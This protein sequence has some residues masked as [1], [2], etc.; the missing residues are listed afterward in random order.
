MIP[1]LPI[2]SRNFRPLAVD[3]HDAAVGHGEVDDAEDDITPVAPQV[4]EPALQENVVLY[5]MIEL[6]PVAYDCRRG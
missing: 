6:M 5:A 2:P 4:G 1:A 3:Q